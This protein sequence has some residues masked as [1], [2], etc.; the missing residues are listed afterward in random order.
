M[1]NTFSA[2]KSGGKVG[3]PIVG[4]SKSTLFMSEI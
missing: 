2:I 1:E 3:G 4:I